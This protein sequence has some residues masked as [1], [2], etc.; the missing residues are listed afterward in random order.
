MTNGLKQKQATQTLNSQHHGDRY[1]IIILKRRTNIPGHSTT[2][3]LKPY[4]F[5]E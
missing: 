2:S 4:L 5:I 3:L 1:E